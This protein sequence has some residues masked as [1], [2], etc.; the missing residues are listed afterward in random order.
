MSLPSKWRRRWKARS[1]AR[2][3]RAVP[4]AWHSRQ[5]LLELQ[6]FGRVLVALPGQELMALLEPELMARPGQES[7]A[8]LEQ[9]LM[10]LTGQELMALLEPE[11]GQE[12]V[13]LFGPELMM[14]LPGQ[15]LLYRALAASRSARAR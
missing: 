10:A 1:R 3:T 13:A 9:E 14:V 11:P 15:E 6:P 4:W 2:S 5:A 8:L 7:M 12:L